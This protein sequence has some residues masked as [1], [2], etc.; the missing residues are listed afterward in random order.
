MLKYDPIE[1]VGAKSAILHP[2]LTWNQNTNAGPQ[3]TPSETN[4]STDSIIPNNLLP[5]LDEYSRIRSKSAPTSGI[6][7]K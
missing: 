1:R 7:S 5:S 3:Q 6:G 2:Y 4:I